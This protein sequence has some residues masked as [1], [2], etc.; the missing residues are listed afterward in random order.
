MLYNIGNKK[1]GFKYILPTSVVCHY[2]LLY[3]Y[4]D[5]VLTSEKLL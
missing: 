5:D 3:H 4:A 2:S 1:N